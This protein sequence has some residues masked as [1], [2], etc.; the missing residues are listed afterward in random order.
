VPLVLEQQ[1]LYAGPTVEGDSMEERC[2]PLGMRDDL[3][4]RGEYDLTEAPDT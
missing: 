3:V 1:V 4:R 2:I